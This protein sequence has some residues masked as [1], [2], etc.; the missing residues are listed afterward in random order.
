V[1]YA[2][3]YRRDDP[4]RKFLQSRVWREKIR[5]AQLAREPLCRFCGVLGRLTL[6]EHID[7]I[8]RPRGDYRLQ[9]NPENFQSLC[10]EHHGMKSKWERGDTTKPLVI[11][12]TPDGWTQVTAPGGTIK[13]PDLS[14]DHKP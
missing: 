3:A 7:H 4:D 1:R 13:R 12:R 14:D 2:D 6:A 8:K 11:G 9:R 5:P 10:A